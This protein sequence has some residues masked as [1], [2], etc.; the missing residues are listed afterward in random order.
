RLS[1]RRSSTWECALLPRRRSPASSEL[2]A[3]G[4]LA[5]TVGLGRL[6]VLCR[7]GGSPQGG[8]VGLRRR[9]AGC[10]FSDLRLHLGGKRRVL[11]QVVADVLT[12]LAQALVSVRHPGAALFE[13]P[14]L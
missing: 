14:V 3:C 1:F 9:A 2:V 10:F 7:T 5:P 6:E 8:G 11:A 4:R 12:A 13:D